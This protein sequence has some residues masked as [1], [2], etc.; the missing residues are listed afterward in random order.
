[1]AT[2]FTSDELEVLKKECDDMAKEVQ[3]LKHKNKTNADSVVFWRDKAIKWMKAG[4]VIRETPNKQIEIWE[5]FN[6]ECDEKGFDL[7][8]WELNFLNHSL[9]ENNA[10]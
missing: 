5:K 3:D 1:M 6:E 4:N 8:Q 10:E 2:I 9:G 7:S